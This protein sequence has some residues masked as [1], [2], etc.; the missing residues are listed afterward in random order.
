MQNA[1]KIKLYQ[2]SGDVRVEENFDVS[3]ENPSSGITSDSSLTL[4][5]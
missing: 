1:A 2:F 4:L 3:G 5:N